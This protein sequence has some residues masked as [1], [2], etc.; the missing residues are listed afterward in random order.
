M[1]RLLHTPNSRQNVRKHR[2]IKY[3]DEYTTLDISLNFGSLE[4]M[5]MK[6]SKP[7]ESLGRSVKGL[8]TYLGFKT[9]IR[10]KRKKGKV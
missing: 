2:D 3:G 5:K 10:S 6:S 1:L 9:I 7:E 4:K 8:V